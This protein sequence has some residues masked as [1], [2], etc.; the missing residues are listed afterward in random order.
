MKKRLTALLGIVLICT[1]VSLAAFLCWNTPQKDTIPI[2]GPPR[3]YL[4]TDANEID[5]QIGNECSACACAY[6]LRHMGI[7]VDSETLYLEIKRVF[8]FVPAS[9][10][11]N[12]LENYGLDAAAYHGTIDTLKERL[13]QGT[14]V[15]V[16]TRIPG[17][18]HY[19]I[20]VGYDDKKVYFIDPKEENSNVENT[21]YNRVLTTDEFE[22]LWK[23]NMYFVNNIYIAVE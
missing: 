20:A 3:E 19:M 13:C 1:T 14:P 11:V 2:N 22:S 23:T 18:T 7:D 15:I 8:G 4:I 21:H 6:V 17:D 16:F 12:V 9:S 5:L 10:L